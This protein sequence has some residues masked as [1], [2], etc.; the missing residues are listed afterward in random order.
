MKTR[1]VFKAEAPHVV[2]LTDGAT[3]NTDAS[4][5]NHFSVTIGASGRTIAAP[6]NPTHGQKIVYELIQNGSGTGTVSFSTGTG[7]F[8]FGT[9]ITAYTMTSTASKTD[10]VGCIY[11]STANKWRIVSIAKG[12]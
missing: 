1:V 11:N 2:A 4:L 8:A 10:Y 3:I 5:G 9:D 7:G 12:Y 6:T